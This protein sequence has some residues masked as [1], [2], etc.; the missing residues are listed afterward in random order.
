MPEIT[1]DQAEA[2]A[3]T[4]VGILKGEVELIPKLTEQQALKMSDWEY[5]IWSRVRKILYAAKLAMSEAALV[6]TDPLAQPHVFAAAAI[7]KATSVGSLAEM[8]QWPILLEQIARF[9]YTEFRG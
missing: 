9:T 2:L 8:D 1:E 4:V 6:S 5:S 7:G 3:K